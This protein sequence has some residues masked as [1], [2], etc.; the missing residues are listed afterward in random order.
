MIRVVFACTHN[1]GA[2][3]HLLRFRKTAGPRAPHPC[4][5]HAARRDPVP[6]HDHLE[7]ELS[8]VHFFRVTLGWGNLIKPWYDAWLPESAIEQHVSEV[9]ATRPRLRGRIAGADQAEAKRSA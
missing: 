1:A 2:G 8:V 5:E 6:R 9:L 3:C 7:W 4:P